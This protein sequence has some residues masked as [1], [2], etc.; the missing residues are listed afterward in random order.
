MQIAGLSYS[1]DPRMSVPGAENPDKVKNIV[2]GPGSLVAFRELYA[3]P[4]GRIEGLEWNSVKDAR[5]DESGDAVL[6][7]RSRQTSGAG[8]TVDGVRARHGGVA[9]GE[10]T[11]QVAIRSCRQ[12]GPVGT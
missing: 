6:R 3:D 8:L 4:L 11:G 10:S 1:G 7:V 5:G 12:N 2:S 9:C